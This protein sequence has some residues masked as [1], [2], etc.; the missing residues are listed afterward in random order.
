MGN[1]LTKTRV[2]SAAPGKTIWDGELKGFGLRV[3]NAGIRS[4][5]LKY[6]NGNI[7]RWFTIG[8]HGSPWTPETARREAKR[9]IGKVQ[10]GGDPSRDRKEER[11]IETISDFADRYLTEH[12]QLKKKPSSAAEDRRNFHNHIIPALG[13]FQVNN[14]SRTDVLRWHSRLSHIPYGANRS[15]ALLSHAMKTAEL[16]GLREPNSNP[17]QHVPKFPEQPRSRFLSEEELVRLG[18]ALS[19]ELANTGN[20]FGIT[21]IRLLLLTGARRSEILG[22]KWKYVDFERHLLRLPDS[23]TGEKT[24]ALPTPAIEILHTLPRHQDN[25]FV[26]CGQKTGQSYINIQR[27]WNR[28]RTQADLHHVRIHDLRHTFASIA[29]MSGMSLPA[30]GSLLGHSQPSTTNRYAHFAADPRIAAS[31][32]VAI[33]IAANLIG[34]D[35]E[36]NPIN[37]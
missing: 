17:C 34:S 20:I 33:K 36:T 14:L 24:I 16:W 19:E 3:T 35:S 15:L 28:V 37:P 30:I 26:I 6:R 5:V 2:E 25:D 8:K 12:S 7:Q 31:D 23:K 4:Y 1:K 22:L 9:L 13:R 18:K 21:A 29:V 27:V 11:Q 32:L 10:S